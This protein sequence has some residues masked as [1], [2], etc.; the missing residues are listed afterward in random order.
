MTM[1]K[2]YVESHLTIKF[3]NDINYQLITDICKNNN[4]DV[5]L[6]ALSF[7]EIELF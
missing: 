3:S 2:F 5:Y 6:I 7:K 1:N 4:A